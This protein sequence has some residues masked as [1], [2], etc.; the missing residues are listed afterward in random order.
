MNII[1]TGVKIQQDAKILS[2]RKNNFVDVINITVDTDESWEYKLDVEYPVNKTTGQKLY[3]VIDLVRN[4]NVCSVVL[5][6]DMLPF[7]G[8]YIMQLRGISSDK[9]YHTDTFEVWVKY[10]IDVGDVYNPVPSEFYQIEDN[11]TEMN[12]HP[13]MPSDD[14]YWM[15]WDVKQHKYV[16]SDIAMD[17]K[18]AVLYTTQNLTD[19]QKQQA[20][21]NIEALSNNSVYYTYL[22]DNHNID[23]Y[24][25]ALSGP[26]G[27]ITGQGAAG[28][29]PP[30]TVIFG[31]INRGVIDAFAI[32]IGGNMY[33]TSL[34]LMGMPEPVWT[35]IEQLRL[36]DDGALPQQTMASS[37]TENMQ[38]AT[39]KYVDD[40]ATGGGGSDPSLGITGAQV[41]QI[42]KITAVDASGVP[43]KWE[44]VDMVSGGGETWETI[45]VITLSDAVNT[46]AINQDSGGNAIALKKV[47]ILVVGSATTNQDLF[48]NNSRYI[49]AAVVGMAA[50]VGALSAEPFCGKMYC[51]A[52]TNI[53]A[54]YASISQLANIFSEEITITEIKLIVN[55]SGTFSAGTKFT[56]QGV[57]A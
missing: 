2:F 23:I 26:I 33:N 17:A 39:K 54:N 46:V 16:K 30:I 42:A 34:N 44:P 5:T 21:E 15:I 6:A 7:N 48:L 49:R 14:G 51:F 27:F 11:I 1:L 29:I 52:V 8:K 20:R 36:N 13:P 38:I 50:S 10:S 4:G 32:D 41:G 22:P 43:T 37:P 9:V 18:N 40:H 25:L 24:K 19:E 28:M 12:N 57:R 3:N 55:N 53:S 47:R 35:K 45:N 56:I 31:A